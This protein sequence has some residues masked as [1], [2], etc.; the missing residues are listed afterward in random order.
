[1]R[2]HYSFII[3]ELFL[4]FM[5][6]NTDEITISSLDISKCSKGCCT[7]L[8]CLNQAIISTSQELKIYLDGD[9]FFLFDS[10]FKT[11]API[12]IIENYTRII[13]PLTC[14]NDP[15]C[16]VKAEIKLK[17]DKLSWDIR[18]GLI[19]KNI[20]INAN[21]I[22]IKNNSTLSCFLTLQGC[23]NNDNCSQ[24]YHYLNNVCGLKNKTVVRNGGQNGLYPF[25]SMNN[26]TIGFYSN[27]T[28]DN[29]DIIN[30]YAINLIGYYTMIYIDVYPT[31]ILFNN[32]LLENFYLLE[33]IVTSN[34]TRRKRIDKIP[35]SFVFNNSTLQFYNKYELIEKWITFYAPSS[36]EIPYII[37]FL[38]SNASFLDSKIFSTA[39][40]LIYSEGSTIF[41]NNI[42]MK[43][44]NM[45]L[46]NDFM[47]VSSSILIIYNLS[48]SDSNATSKFIG[49]SN[50][51]KIS[52]NN[53]FIGS[54]IFN[55][56][57]AIQLAQNSSLNLLNSKFYNLTGTIK[58]VF[59]CY[60]SVIQSFNNQFINIINKLLQLDDGNQ[61]NSTNDI[62]SGF[63]T[64]NDTSFFGINKNNV[65]L[66][67]NI[68]FSNISIPNIGSCMEVSTPNSLTFDNISA[69]TLYSLNKS[70]FLNI[71][72]LNT[73]S[74]I[75]SKIIGSKGFSC[76][77]SS[78]DSN[79][80]SITNSYFSDCYSS[81]KGGII[82]GN[83]MNKVFINSSSFLNIQA[84]SDG[85]AIFLTNNNV[86]I[87][88]LSSF[89][90]VNS[91]NTGGVVSLDTSNNILIQNSSFRNCFTVN[92]DNNNNYSKGGIIFLNELNVIN[93]VFSIFIKSSSTLGGALYA[94]ESNRIFINDSEFD[95]NQAI[96]GGCLYIDITN[97]LTLQRCLFYNSSSSDL[98]GILIA[99]TENQIIINDC[100]FMKASSQI[101]GVIY[102]NSYNQMNIS[103]V[104]MNLTNSLVRGSSLFLN[105]EN[106]VRISNSTFQNSFSL[107]ESG[108][109]YSNV[110]NGLYFYQVVFKN[111]SAKL[112]G[113]AIFL[114]YKNN[115]TMNVG[116]FIDTYADLKG[117]SFYVSNKNIMNVSNIIIDNLIN[118]FDFTIFYL[119][120]NFFNL[121]NITLREGCGI[122]ISQ[123]NQGSLENITILNLN[124]KRNQFTSTMTDDLKEAS[125][126]EDK[127]FI[128][129][130]SSVMLLKSMQFS[131]LKYSL[132][133]SLLSNVTIENLV[134][135]YNS[136]SNDND[137]YLMM[138]K[139]SFV[140][141]KNVNFYFN[142]AH[143]FNFNGSTVNLQKF[144]VL[145][146]GNTY[147]IFNFFDG[148][149]RMH[150][151]IFKQ[152]P[153]IN[154]NLN[155]IPIISF[156][157]K[158]NF[159][160]STLKAISITFLYNIG[161]EGSSL[162]AL[163]SNLTIRNCAFYMNKAFYSGGAISFIVQQ[164]YYPMTQFNFFLQISNSVFFKNSAS[165]K[166]GAIKLENFIAKANMTIKFKY[167]SFVWNK[168]NLGGCFYVKDYTSVNITNALF[169]NNRGIRKNSP[170][171]MN[172]NNLN[173]NSD[174]KGGAVYVN[175][176]FNNS[177]INY[178]ADLKIINNS[179]DIGGVIFFENQTLILP[180]VLVIKNN[181]ANLY[182][183]VFATDITKIYF[184]SIYEKKL[185]KIGF[186]NLIS[187]DAYDC[188]FSIIGYDDFGQSVIS[189]SD[190]ISEN[191]NFTSL[192]IGIN[193]FKNHKLF[194]KKN[195]FGSYC[196]SNKLVPI[197]FYSTAVDILIT[198]KSLRGSN[199]NVDSKLNLFLSFR[200]CIIGEIAQNG[201]C[202]KCSNKTYSLQV[203]LEE[204]IICKETDPFYCYGGA[205]LAPRPGYWR[206][207]YY[208]DNFISCPNPNSCLGAYFRYDSDYSPALAS[209]ECSIG[210]SGVLC[211]ECSDTYGITDK[212]FCS[213]CDDD[214][215]YF[216]I[217]ASL[218][219]KVIIILFSVHK[220][221]IMCLSLITSNI[222]NLRKVISS[223]L[224]KILFNH[225]Q[226][227]IIVFSIPS[228]I[229]PEI[230]KQILH[231]S[232]TSSPNITEIISLECALKKM[233][234]SINQQTL[235]LVTIWTSP[236]IIILISSGYLAIYLKNKKKNMLL[237]TYMID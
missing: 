32:T 4:F 126:N 171:P 169:Y 207:N 15:F 235:K 178:F 26:N 185:N 28:F 20:K 164:S 7:F 11:M 65:I 151:G 228:L 166:G 94:Q 110:F 214:D 221:M 159:D 59:Y 54:C 168:A 67:K 219:I 46:N 102:L 184:E 30:F 134:V 229:M 103:K 9:Y 44:I 213:K 139:L 205:D 192:I 124:Y 92:I 78:Q 150:K 41:F 25:F 165:D 111:I 158:F 60:L 34:I 105:E 64:S 173:E 73:I 116:S 55:N 84:S 217:V 27:L 42:K 176:N 87:I 137:C 106:V 114:Y 136:L 89:Y 77:L 163:N 70:A 50:N 130:L 31:N 140:I 23:C 167:N 189:H 191:F 156:V 1:M 195:E 206:Y 83:Q 21:D 230:I 225:L 12:K 10:D 69:F 36:V 133:S 43:G 81:F 128:M 98:G 237:K 190:D 101:G 160:L 145:Y 193:P 35:F 138:F 220:A 224:M 48:F 216:Y 147:Q 62:F 121:S 233:K 131:H 155:E 3:I 49:T 79:T 33:G 115:M 51:N 161:Y 132:I 71:G 231:F 40:K 153:S 14:K 104:L 18:G 37:V 198:Y 201:Y 6:V 203:G 117:G 127:I 120:N 38:T 108:S 91:D 232:K 66:F 75:D 5:L 181:T 58:P 179:A 13:S 90:N 204:C 97:G 129:I 212:F 19:F 47:V 172:S 148:N 99:Q 141:I 82:S 100:S 72:S 177:T 199:P 112:R 56:T 215:I 53:S 211:A 39:Y 197:P 86:I 74:F 200:S 85:G 227:L 170:F 175:N 61:W 122:Y 187:G 226:C 236:V 125:V 222:V 95:M 76:F 188:L 146:S 218:V 143:L 2:M 180:T 118:E 24:P 107:E 113:G 194:L 208:S 144:E 119:N 183:P 154:Q 80:I 29:C 45:K 210:Y 202:S 196:S 22:H 57:Y 162:K 135:H 52:I 63:K 234:L 109:I 8:D 16:S 182:G 142:H 17:T 174:S 186:Y 209:G 149:I 88:I 152:L 157:S 123:F 93:I 96:Q 223:I 68:L